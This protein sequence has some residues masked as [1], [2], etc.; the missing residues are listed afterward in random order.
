[1]ALIIVLHV[2]ADKRTDVIEEWSYVLWLSKF[3]IFIFVFMS[4]VNYVVDYCSLVYF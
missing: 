3:F 4:S 1:M 2:V